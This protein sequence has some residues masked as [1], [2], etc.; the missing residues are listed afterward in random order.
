M[1]NMVLCYWKISLAEWCTKQFFGRG[2]LG[3]GESGGG[4]LDRGGREMLLFFTV[5][6]SRSLLLSIC[7]HSL[8]FE[9]ANQFCHSERD[10]CRVRKIL[11][12]RCSIVDALHF[13]SCIN[14][15][16]INLFE[17]HKQ[18]NCF[19]MLTFQIAMCIIILACQCRVMYAN[20]INIHWNKLF[21][22]PPSPISPSPCNISH[23][24]FPSLSLVHSAGLRFTYNCMS[25]VVCP[26]L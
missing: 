15:T 5:L 26:K 17:M 9:R 7:F 14:F 1:C 24:L 22:Q 20:I 16:L 10:C 25:S 23:F 11:V 18:A 19:Y 12:I 3:R 6:L 8:S 13:V 4:V 2:N 21:R